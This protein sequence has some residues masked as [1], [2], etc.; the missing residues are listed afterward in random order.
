[1]A[2]IDDSINFLKNLSQPDTWSETTDKTFKY[3]SPEPAAK[4]ETITTGLPPWVSGDN[5]P[6]QYDLVRRPPLVEN[7][8]RRGEMVLLT[9]TSKMGKSWFMMNLA[10][11]MS[12][13]IPFLGLET[14]K[15]NVLMLDLELSQADAMDRL[16]SIALANG[17]KQPPKNLHLW[18]LRKYCYDLDVIIETLNNRLDQIPNLD[19]IFLD[20]VYMLGQSEN[21]D[22]NSSSSITRLLTDLEKITLKTDAS[23]F[24]T[25][26]FRKG[27]MGRESHI[28]R[29]AG[30]GV[31]ARMVDCIIS[32]S[33]HQLP[34]HAIFEMTSRSQKAPKPFVLKMTPP[35]ITVAENADPTAYRRYGSPTCEEITD[36]TILEIIPTGQSLTKQEWFSKARMQG[37]TESNFNTHFTS[38]R[39][40]GKVKVVDRDGCNAYSRT[41]E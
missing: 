16:W 4:A 33:P 21:F 24:C 37:V 30:S 35:V 8:C 10:T 18:S 25:H 36:E 26:H 17:L 41:V 9:A 13:G 20:P 34:D 38:L 23:L 7:F 5:F 12:E 19:A 40:S 14:V 2:T 29:G 6:K 32:L 31:F 15:S 28:D 39:S 22:E 11:S 27:N 3:Q 1:M